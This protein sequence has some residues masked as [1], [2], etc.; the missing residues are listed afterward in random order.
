MIRHWIYA[1]GIRI[2]GKIVKCI[3]SRNVFGNGKL[4]IDKNTHLIFSKDSKINIEGTLRLNDKCII[5]NGRSTILRIEQDG[6]FDC[7]GNVSIFYGGDIIIFQGGNLKIGNSYINSD[8]KIRCH[9]SISIGND[10]AISHNV[11]IMDSDAHYLNGNNNKQDVKIGNHVWIGSHV[12]I[13]SGVTIGND[14]VIAAGS[15]VTK[16]VES[17]TMVAGV[18]AKVIKNN[19]EWSK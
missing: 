15:L 13:L 4:Y 5:N 14:S 18:P 6:V 7:K 12:T 1:L 2:R 19:V 11:T 8:S 9:K 3:R 16:D 17:K 10:C